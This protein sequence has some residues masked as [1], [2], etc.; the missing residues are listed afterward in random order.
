MSFS[1]FAFLF[2]I[3]CKY[4]KTRGATMD[5]KKFYESFEKTGV[6]KESFVG[7]DDVVETLEEREADE[8][9]RFAELTQLRNKAI[10]EGLEKKEIDALTRQCDE[11]FDKI[12]TGVDQIPT[13]DEEHTRSDF[14]KD[15]DFSSIKQSWKQ[16]RQDSMLRVKELNDRQADLTQNIAEAE[17][18]YKQLGV[19]RAEIESQIELGDGTLSP[20]KLNELQEGLDTIK[21][22]QADVLAELKDRRTELDAVV[23][24]HTMQTFVNNHAKT[25]QS[26]A[27]SMHREQVLNQAREA[28]RD[29]QQALSEKVRDFA[30]HVK[31]NARMVKNHVSLSL[32]LSDLNFT[33]LRDAIEKRHQ[34]EAVKKIEEIQ[35]TKEKISKIEEK[36]LKRYNKKAEQEFARKAATNKLAELLGEQKPHDISETFESR[37]QFS[38]EMA[39]DLN[40]FRMAQLTKLAADLG[41]QEQEFAKALDQIT[42]DKEAREARLEPVKEKIRDAMEQNALLQKDIDS[43][44]KDLE[45]AGFSLGDNARDQIQDALDKGII[46][47]EAIKEMR[48][49]LE[50]IGLS[51]DSQEHEAPEQD[52]PELG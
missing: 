27:A 51:V 29:K 10:E 17:K 45:N 3:T 34:K 8:I 25:Q 9:R 15:A 28:I 32:K 26:Q 2:Y 42:K 16:I 48:E 4:N 39:S 14:L 49:K 30:D 36:A 46:S 18:S 52:A 5:L 38:L 50:N 40:K 31:Q 43:F 6:S 22:D 35:K 7:F 41:K 19:E 44:A 23:A 24:E 11:A 21:K 47:P 20:E 33:P 37:D 12:F 13:F 1:F